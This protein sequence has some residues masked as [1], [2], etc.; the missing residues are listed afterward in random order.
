[1]KRKYEVSYYE[2]GLT[3]R[4]AKKFFCELTAYLYKG[5]LEYKFKDY[6]KVRVKEL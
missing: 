6:A 3:N 5:Y 1:M 2:Y 4:T